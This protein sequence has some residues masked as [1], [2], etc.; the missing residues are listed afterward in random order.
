[1]KVLKQKSSGRDD[2]QAVYNTIIFNLELVNKL[3][4]FAAKT[5]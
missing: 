4:M 2:T 3:I 1:M 5:Y